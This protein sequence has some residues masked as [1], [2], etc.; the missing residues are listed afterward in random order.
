MTLRFTHVVFGVSSSLFL[1]NA[2][3]KDH[4]EEYRDIHP[5]FVKIFARSIYVDDVTYGA[6]DDVAAFELYVRS[7]KTLAE[8]GFNLRKFVSNS[9]SLQRC[10]EASEGHS[11]FEEKKG[12]RVV[13]EDKTYT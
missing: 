1:L 7:K 13:E 4:V 10:I 6:S 8:E 3:I 2:T 9:Q 5:E 11:S 12:C